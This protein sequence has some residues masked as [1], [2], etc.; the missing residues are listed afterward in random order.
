MGQ[1]VSENCFA[2][3]D[4][5]SHTSRMLVA[6]KHGT[7][8]VTIRMERKV[9]RL[10]REFSDA[11]VITEEAQ[12][13]NISAIKEYISIL[14]EF[15]AG[16]I[17][18]GATGVVRR[19]K[20]SCAVL[21]R[22]TAETGIEC[23]ILSEK[24]EAI[25]SAKGIMSV[26]PETGNDLLTFDIGGGSTEFLLT[27]RGMDTSARSAS[28]PLGAA[29]LTEKYLSDD[30]P[31]TEAVEHAALAAR[32]EIISSKQQLYENLNNTGTIPS[33]ELAG[34][35][36]TV[37]TLAA[38]YMK[39]GH[40]VPYRVNGL[41]LTKDWLSHTIESLAQMRLDQRRLIAG[42]EPGRED[43]ILGG[44]VIVSE[45]LSCFS[46]DSFIVT[47]AGLLE[48]ILIDLVEKESGLS[49]GEAAGLRTCLTWRLQKG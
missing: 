19:A 33:L 21:S 14:R 49:G 9:T 32:N 29:T 27:L 13:R 11:G 18:C 22:I 15:S 4:I 24:T 30:P 23:K 34:T 26:L 46:R 45:I 31:G 36:G 43:I 41:I 16:K 28:R 1:S 25:L 7:E 3:I 40:Y 42:L 47:D 48:G 12:Q 5:G 44:A 10:A 8:L 37:T 35:A 39:M 6:Q 2:G 17:A 38:M 20:N